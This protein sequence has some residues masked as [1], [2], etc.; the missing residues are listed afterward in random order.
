V[1]IPSSRHRKLGW[2]S[3][4]VICLVLALGIAIALDR[5]QVARSVRSTP[6]ASDQSARLMV[7]LLTRGEA[8]GRELPPELREQFGWKLKPGDMAPDFILPMIEEPGEIALNSFRGTPVV[9]AFGSMTCNLFCDDLSELYRLH[10]DYHDRAA[11]LFVYV[12]E[13]GHS[14][15]GFEFLLEGREPDPETLRGREGRPRAPL[16]H[17]RG[18]VLQAVEKVHMKL[19]GVIDI[20]GT[21]E[22]AYDAFPRR[23]LVIDADGRV[24]IDLGKGVLVRWDFFRVEEW[25]KAH[26]KQ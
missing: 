4:S 1:S 9:L 8:E 24:A 3:L 26:P 5:I 14:L 16:P 23:L 15:K 2:K 21:V 19:P 7:S 6:D 17:R 25:L 22:V 11:F 18:L 10:R 13:A 12:T 20:D